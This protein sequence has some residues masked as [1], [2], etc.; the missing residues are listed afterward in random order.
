MRL[1]VPSAPTRPRTRCSRSHQDVSSGIAFRMR[2]IAARRSPS[3][4]RQGR[5]RARRRRACPRWGSAASSSRR[6]KA[7]RSR[8][9]RS[10]SWTTSATPPMDCSPFVGMPQAPEPGGC[11]GPVSWDRADA[12]ETAVGRADHGNEA[13]RAA[14]FRSTRLFG[15]AARSEDDLAITGTFDPASAAFWMLSA[16]APSDTMETMDDGSCTAHHA[17][18]RR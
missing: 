18:R 11:P 17:A 8:S 9:G 1:A 14:P 6:R 13:F 5:H 7:R 3:A 2:T 16:A 4:W 15:D 10:E 12:R